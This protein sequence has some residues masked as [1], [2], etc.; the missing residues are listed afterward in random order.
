ME[1]SGVAKDAE[2]ISPGLLRG[3]CV[4]FTGRLASLT[5]GEAAALVRDHAG[6]FVRGVTR[7]TTMLVV[8]QEGWPLQKDGR[9]TRKLLRAR[10]LDRAG[11]RIAIVPEQSLLSRLGLERA[12]A[13]ISRLY[14]IVQLSRILHVPRDRIRAWVRGGLVQPTETVHALPYFEFRQVSSAKTLCELADAGVTLERLRRSLMQLRRWM[15][16]VDQPLAQLAVLQRDGRML[17][18]LEAGQLAEPTGQLNFD[19]DPDR[20]AVTA[21]SVTPSSATAQELFERGIE[22]ERCGRLQEAA[23]AYRHA[24]LRAGPQTEICFNLANVLDALGH[25]AQAAERLWQV[26]EMDRRHVAAWNNLGNVLAELG[27]FAEA[28]AAFKQAL[29]IE[30]HYADAHYNLADAL[31]QMGEPLKAMPHWEQYLR[32]DASSPWADYARRRLSR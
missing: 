17:L 7:H 20:P 1:R 31:D 18:R 16:D 2:I 30:P 21:I 5:R 28:V 29:A 15:P 12:S 26:V 13:A 25:K 10:A 32:Q 24:L 23:E 6:R 9:L 27:Q 11:C 4:A 3:E 19:F 22:H 14:T 8:G